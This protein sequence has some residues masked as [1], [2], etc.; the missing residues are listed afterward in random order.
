MQD[1]NE[2]TSGSHK[3]VVVG[4]MLASSLAVCF[5]GDVVREMTAS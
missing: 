5:G 2:R 1:L 3:R 4:V